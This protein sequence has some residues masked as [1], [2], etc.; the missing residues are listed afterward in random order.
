MD[1]EVA[2]YGIILKSESFI[3]FSMCN[4]FIILFVFVYIFELY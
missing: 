1:K 3:R 2:V 4:I